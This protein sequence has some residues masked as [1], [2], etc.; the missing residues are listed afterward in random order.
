M[1]YRWL[2]TV[3][4]FAHLMMPMPAFADV[5]DTGCACASWPESNCT[6]KTITITVDDPMPGGGREC[7]NN[8]TSTITLTLSSERTWGCYADDYHVWIEDPGTG[9]LISSTSANK[10]MVDP[11]L[12]GT[13]GNH[14]WRNTPVSPSNL[15]ADSAGRP[16]SL[17]LAESPGYANM[18]MGGGCSSGNYGDNRF[19]YTFTAVPT[20]PADNGETVLRPPWSGT[21]KQT[22]STNDID[23][24]ILPSFNANDSGMPALMPAQDMIPRCIVESYHFTG[25]Y[26]ASSYPVFNFQQYHTDG[27]NKFSKCAA[28]IAFSQGTNAPTL[29]QRQRMGIGLITNGLAIRNVLKTEN[30]ASFPLNSGYGQNATLPVAFAAAAIPGLR[31]EFKNRFTQSVGISNRTG[32]EFDIDGGVWRH[33]NGNVYFGYGWPNQT[34]GVGYEPC[35]HKENADQNNTCRDMNGAETDRWPLGNYMNCCVMGAWFGQAGIFYAFPKIYELVAAS[36]DAGRKFFDL[37]ERYDQVGSA[38]F[39]GRDKV[40]HRE[41]ISEALFDA[42]KGC[43]RTLGGSGQSIRVSSYNAG[44]VGHAGADLTPEPSSPIA[45]APPPFLRE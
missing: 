43:S 41:I 5:F 8:G 31:S 4:L 19:A 34:P 10:Y 36:N 38:Q 15:N 13:S 17:T 29:A 11:D 35:A 16:V 42:I 1:T 40:A 14:P 12:K 7:G 37:V 26:S 45:D 39:G 28:H 22:F 27:S 44:C 6:G 30:D 20:V 32:Y 25:V 2:T 33:G 18:S 24:T 21:S 23:W 9:V 3:A